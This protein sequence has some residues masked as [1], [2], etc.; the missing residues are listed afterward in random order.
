MRIGKNLKIGAKLKRKKQNFLIIRKK[1]GNNKVPYA[2]SLDVFDQCSSC[3]SR[4]VS[5]EIFIDSSGRRSALHCNSCG[6]NTF[7]SPA[8]ENN[9]KEGKPT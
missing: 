8:I 2:P 6:C 3:G 5:K 7:Y 9:P 4:R 1:R